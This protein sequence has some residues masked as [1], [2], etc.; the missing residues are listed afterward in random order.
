VFRD[1]RGG[2]F[3]I[4]YRASNGSIIIHKSRGQLG[5]SSVFPWRAREGIRKCEGGSCN[6]SYR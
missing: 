2:L 1:A 5:A 6:G 3:V 4:I